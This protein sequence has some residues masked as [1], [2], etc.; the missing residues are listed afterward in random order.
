MAR[1][2]LAEDLKRGSAWLTFKFVAEFLKTV[3]A[4]DMAK[5]TGLEFKPLLATTFAKEQ[6]WI[7][8]NPPVQAWICGFDPQSLLPKSAAAR[9]PPMI[10]NII[11]KL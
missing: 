1:C 7:C 10:E 4:K 5:N 8:H 2:R 11:W 3:V 9:T 6:I